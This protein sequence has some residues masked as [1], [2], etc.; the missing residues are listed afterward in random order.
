VLL[1]QKKVEFENYQTETDGKLL[2]S[3]RYIDKIERDFEIR[4]DKEEKKRE[5]VLS[6]LATVFPKKK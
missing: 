4:I 2:Q 6:K 3:R 5:T 1:N